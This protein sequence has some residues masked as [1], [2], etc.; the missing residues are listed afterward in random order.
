MRCEDVIF[1]TSIQDSETEA[2][3]ELRFKTLDGT[4]INRRGG[5]IILFVGINPGD[6]LFC[7]STV[8]FLWEISSQ[9]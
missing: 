3:Y 2:R 1:E 5:G 7:K 9:L 4:L 8:V 6:K